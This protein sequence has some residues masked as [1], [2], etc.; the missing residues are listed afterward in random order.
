[1]QSCGKTCFSFSDAY[2]PKIKYD[3]LTWRKAYADEAWEELEMSFADCKSCVQLHS[4]LH[5]RLCCPGIHTWDSNKNI[6][7]VGFGTNGVE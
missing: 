5:V 2:M 6:E 4:S 3:G 7:E 1:M